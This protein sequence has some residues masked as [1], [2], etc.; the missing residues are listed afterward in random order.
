MKQT[1]AGFILLV[2]LSVVLSTLVIVD[3]TAADVTGLVEDCLD[4]HGNAGASKVPGIPIIGGLSAQ[5]IVDSFTAYM[6]KSR[7]C[8]GM[9]KSTE[10]LSGEEVK[11]VADHFASKPFVRA[12]QTFDPGLATKGKRVHALHCKKCHEDGGSSPDDDAGILAGQWMHYMEGQFEDYATGRRY[13]PKKMKQKMDKISGED[14][15]A[16]IHY[17]GSFQGPVRD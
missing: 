15:K 14:T 10:K 11:Q 9:C 8:N 17:Y 12:N 2:G 1:M 5:Y 3:A 16:L 4:C 7:P 6:D 13:M